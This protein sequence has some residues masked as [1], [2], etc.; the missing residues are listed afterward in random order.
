MSKSNISKRD[1]DIFHITMHWSYVRKNNTN[2]RSMSLWIIYDSCMLQLTNDH[3]QKIS[4]LIRSNVST[5]YKEKL[6]YCSKISK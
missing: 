6:T 3:G 5:K 4:L 1:I 2:S